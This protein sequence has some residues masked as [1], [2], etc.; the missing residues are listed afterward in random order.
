LYAPGDKIWLKV[1]Q[2]NGITHKLN[3]NFRNVFIQLI[4]DNGKVVKDLRLFSINGQA[5][6]NFGTDSLPNGTYILRAYTKYLLNYGEEACFHKKIWISKSLNSFD[7][8]NSSPADTEEFDISFLPE[9]GKL[10]PNTLNNMAFK[11]ID[12]KGKGIYITGNILDDRGDTI[13]AFSSSYLGMG[14]LMFMPLDDRSYYAIFDRYPGL[15][16]TLPPTEKHGIG[17]ICK[18]NTET[19]RVGLSTN[20]KSEA[21]RSFHFFATQKGIV[22]FHEK[23]EMTD[24]SES[25]DLDK[26]IFPIGISKITLLDTLLNPIAERLVFIDDGKGDLLHVQMNK[27]EFKPREKVD[28]DIGAALASDDSIISTISVAVV[29]KNY[30][31]TGEFNQN[32]KSYLLLDSELKGV[33]ELPAMYF[34]DDKFHSSAEKLDLL[35]LVH[36]WRSYIW[37]D[38]EQMPTPSLDDWNDAGIS[39][40]GIVKKSLW[41]T[42]ATETDVALDYV[43]RNYRISTTTT[44]DNGRFIFDH[45]YLIDTLKVMLNAKKGKAVHNFEIKLDTL[46]QTESVVPAGLLKNAGIDIAPGFNFNRDNW[47]RQTKELEFNPEKGTILLEGVD[48]IEQR[49]KAFFRS[50]GAILWS[51]KTLT[52]K[53]DDYRFGNVIRYLKDTLPGLVDHDDFIMQGKKELKFLVNG[54]FWALRDIK[55]MRLNGIDKIDMFA[56]LDGKI[57]WIS[58]SQKFN[59]RATDLD[60]EFVK[61]RLYLGLR[62]FHRPA[63]FYSPKYTPENIASPRPDFRPTLYWNPNL[64]LEDGKMN[65]EFFT[66]DELA[67]YVVVVEGISQNGEICFGTTSFSV[68]KK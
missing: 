33:I 52:L 16:I 46:P 59:T 10:V 48:V 34:T 44:D 62:G 36:G 3:S 19:L 45:I 65:I 35:M 64:K 50:Y 20:T 2:V 31:G 30:L 43:F 8:Q 26:A 14:Q 63:I 39:I 49:T 37:N 21:N 29:N 56:T 54:D 18:Q 42:P 11:A 38:V 57:L 55:L 23:I 6:G 32:I 66:S 15:K 41:N 68:D 24:F 5:N 58:I 28:L 13:V 51:D 61:G 1:Y 60:D 40:S 12:K 47:F 9:G 22:L 53:K 7:T 27:N 4:A 25:L 17:M 67:Q